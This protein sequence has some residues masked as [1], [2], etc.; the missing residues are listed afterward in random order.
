MSGGMQRLKGLALGLG[1]EIERQNEQ[2]DRIEGK[3]GRA[4]TTIR[5][6]NKQIRG[7][8]GYKKKWFQPNIVKFRDLEIYQIFCYNVQIS[9]TSFL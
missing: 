3:V 7:I 9:V 2:I 6:Q 8:L 1:D 4:D 5:D